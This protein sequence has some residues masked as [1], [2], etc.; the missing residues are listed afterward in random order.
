MKGSSFCW[1]QAEPHCLCFYQ[2]AF[3]WYR[4]VHLKFMP[5][6]L[7]SEQG[8]LISLGLFVLLIQVILFLL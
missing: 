4:S 2:C 6:I 7:M 1:Y 3:D 5:E 8:I